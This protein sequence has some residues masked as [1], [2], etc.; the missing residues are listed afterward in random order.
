MAKTRID[1]KASI[2]TAAY[3]VFYGEG[4]SR[5]SMDAIAAVA[6]VTKRSVYYH[7]QSKDDV[8]AEVLR[9]Q[10][11]HSIAQ[12]A[13]W[14]GADVTTAPQVTAR[15]FDRLEDWARQLKIWAH[16]GSLRPVLRFATHPSNVPRPGRHHRT[17]DGCM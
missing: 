7:F 3:Q 1:T 4:F 13:D 14:I 17:T 16:S 11:R 8:V 15:L 12:F 10:D 9:H 6:D 5:V 2:L